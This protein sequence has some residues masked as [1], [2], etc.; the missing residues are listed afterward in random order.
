MFR[1]I[2]LLAITWMLAATPCAVATP[3]AGF[4]VDSIGGSFD[5]VVGAIGIGDGRVLAWERTGKLWMIDQSGVRAS[6]PVL[7]I[8]DEVQG[9]GDGGLLGLA[10]H[11]KFPIQPDVFLL[12]AVDRHHLLY[13]G[14]PA[15]NRSTNLYYKATIGRITRYSLDKA[16]NLST[17]L[18]ASR[19]VLIGSSATNGIPI[20]HS[21]HMIGSI[22]FGSDGS[23]LAST[24][25]N[26]NFSVIDTGGAALNAN[27]TDAL[28]DGI[29]RPEED[30]G[31]FRS[32]MIDSLCGKILRIDPE[33]G[34]GLSSN[35]WFDPAGPNR[36]RSKVWALGLRNP[37]R[38][39]IVPESGSH[40]PGDANPGTLLIGDV[41]WG[42]PNSEK[43]YVVKRG[44]LN[45][46]WPLYEGFAPILE[47][48]Q[49]Q[50]VDRAI[51]LAPGRFGPFSDRLQEVAPNQ[52]PFIDSTIVREAEDSPASTDGGAPINN[53]QA[54]Y[55]GTGFR[56]LWSS[57]WVDFSLNQASTGPAIVA[58][59]YSFAGSTNLPIQISVDGVPLSGSWTVAPTG[60]PTT[61][62]VARIPIP[63]L[64]TGT[65]SIRISKG[66]DPVSLL[67]DCAWLESP[68]NLPT[69]P[70][71]V[72]TFVCHEPCIGWRG[73][74]RTPGFNAFGAPTG[75]VVGTP[76]GASGS[77]FSGL[78]VVG[79][80]WIDFPSWPVEQHGIY[81]GD[82]VNG[83]IRRLDADLSSQCGSKSAECKCAGTVRSV[84]PYDSG[85]Q[86]LV[87]L[88]AEPFSQSLLSAQWTTLRRYRWLP[89]GSLAPDIRVST[90]TLHGPSPLTIMLDASASRDPE[91]LSLSFEW[92]FSDGSPTIAG[93]VAQC[94]LANPGRSP[95]RVDVLLR[96]TDP[97]GASSTRSFVVGLDNS[98]PIFTIHAPI[99]GQRYSTRRD[100]VIPLIAIAS[101]AEQPEESLKFEW[102]T[103]L[104]HDTHTHPE[105]VDTAPITEAT[106]QA[107]HCSDSA[108]YWYEVTLSVE[109]P[110]GLR[111]SRTVRLDPD[112]TGTLGC[113]GDIEIDGNVNFADLGIMLLLLGAPDPNA[114]LDGNGLVEPPDIAEM[115][116]LW[117]PCSS[118]S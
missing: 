78:C 37:F 21:S 98:P 1:A 87:G 2:L 18:P 56:G 112:C 17:A 79:G 108:T 57:R 10:L 109:D 58:L 29:I 14:T 114:D 101:D 42:K 52:E 35:P 40:D 48:W 6:T 111:S 28:A 113:R 104:H 110:G 8:S 84:Q 61:W 97:G 66:S 47:F 74:A 69:L 115:L 59:R 24:G 36:A 62:R 71:S 65:H 70:A 88:F 96:V 25:D 30:V 49:A 54:G 102:Q 91:G 43:V 103:V 38:V 12:Y 117:G 81:V 76:G 27:V 7:D 34:S 19:K 50:T 95:K 22:M 41:G 32:Q 89:S 15:Y 105:P 100:T 90:T 107:T 83:W 67:A 106:L 75:V 72:P 116:L 51:P 23:L 93:P 73:D 86:G 55:F 39:T 77:S 26:A 118:S 82:Y 60:A 3:P 11:P 13:A 80:P 46:G 44:G 9:G 31:A 33:T 68:G 85:I 16:N 4:V 45:M 20:L 5:C 94:V 53:N 63:N 92:N 99:D 64:S